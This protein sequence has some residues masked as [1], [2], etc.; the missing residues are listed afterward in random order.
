M[1]MGG[2]KNGKLGGKKAREVISPNGTKG[3]DG[4][5]KRG[6]TELELDLNEFKREKQD[7]NWI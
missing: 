1:V 5:F 6:K 7:W 4:I 3:F 2:K